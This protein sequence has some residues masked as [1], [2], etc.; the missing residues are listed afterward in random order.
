MAISFIGIEME[1]F[2]KKE[3][4]KMGM[5]LLFSTTKKGKK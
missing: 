2:N 1:K 3:N 4:S 5:E